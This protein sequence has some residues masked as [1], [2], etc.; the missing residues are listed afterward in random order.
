MVE[1]SILNMCL[2]L[3][4]QA[5]PFDCWRV[6]GITLSVSEDLGKDD[7]TVSPALCQ[8]VSAKL[9]AQSQVWPPPS[10]HSV[11]LMQHNLCLEGGRG[12]GRA[13]LAYEMWGPF[14]LEQAPTAC[15][16]CSC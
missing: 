5:E 4:S 9:S 8:A 13:A 16:Q 2:C 12:G 15:V 7:H 11:T 14:I 6:Y 1:W 10:P 3:S